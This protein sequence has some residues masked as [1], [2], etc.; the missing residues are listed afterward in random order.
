VVRFCGFVFS[1]FAAARSHTHALTHSLHPFPHT[2]KHRGEASASNA[3]TCVALALPTT[4]WAAEGEAGMRVRGAWARE[5]LMPAL[6][7]PHRPSQTL[8]T[9]PFLNTILPHAAPALLAIGRS[10]GSIDL[11]CAHTGRSVSPPIPP[12]PAGLGASEEAVAAAARRAA[13]GDPAGAAPTNDAPPPPSSVAG[14]AFLHTAAG[15]GAKHLPLLVTASAG[16]AVRAFAPPAPLE[17][18]V[19]GGGAGEA[20]A[21]TLVSKFTVPPHVTALAV[22]PSTPSSTRIALTFRGTEP[23]VWD[24]A[25]R[26][27]TFEARGAKPDALGLVERP[28]GTAVAFPP[29]HGG[30]LLAVG[31]VTGKVRLYDPRHGRRPLAVVD[32]AAG[33]AGCS[34]VGAV[35]ARVSALAPDPAHP[36][37]GRLWVG[38]ARGL[39]RCVDLRAKRVEGV[40]KGPTGGVRG[41]AVHPTQRLVASVGLDGWVRVHHAETRALLG[42]AYAK[43]PLTGLAVCPA[44]PG[45]GAAPEPPPPTPDAK[46]LK[47]MKKRERTTP[48]AGEVFLKK[49]RR[50]KKLEKR[51]KNKKKAAA[52]AAGRG[53]GKRASAGAPA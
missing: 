33:A 41:V 30:H 3:S 45:S 7:P 53:G 17:E 42:S 2:H 48:I 1:F 18:L 25:S 32:V 23:A 21:W 27:A 52:K 11:V 46:A 12:P 13:G 51:R 4:E 20:P 35:P 49:T 6:L 36:H 14:L 38:T 8:S 28:W 29:G 47:K 19:K 34:T 9:P 10:T 15:T 24:V 39:L 22:D 50:E 16:G 37:W 40:L 26:E 44:P 5:T 43:Q 31:T